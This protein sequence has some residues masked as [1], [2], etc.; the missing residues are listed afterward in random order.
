M[1]KKISEY[2]AEIGRKGGKAPKATSA[3]NGAKGG[4]IPEERKAAIEREVGEPVAQ[5]G[6]LEKNDNG[7]AL[8]RLTFDNGEV[9]Y[10]LWGESGT[11][12][13]PWED[14]SEARENWDI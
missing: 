2:M 8:Y 1:D 5:F 10:V 13:G 7:A 14:E 4:R 11:I 6:I 9:R 3:A 12:L